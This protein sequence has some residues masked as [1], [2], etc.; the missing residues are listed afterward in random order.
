[1]LAGAAQA[2]RLDRLQRRAFGLEPADA[3]PLA[4]AQR[5]EAQAD[6][7]ADRAAVARP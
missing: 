5:V 3:Q 2:F 4:L 1:M 7:L 6:V